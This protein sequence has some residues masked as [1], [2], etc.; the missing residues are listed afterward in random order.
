MPP[1]RSNQTP[2]GPL[3]TTNGSRFAP[4]DLA[5]LAVIAFVALAVSAI[6]G[7]DSLAAPVVL[8]LALGLLVLAE[9]KVAPAPG[10]TQRHPAGTRAGV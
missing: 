4:A 8:L 6:I 1:E 7:F 2:T 9:H 3:R 10:T 5:G